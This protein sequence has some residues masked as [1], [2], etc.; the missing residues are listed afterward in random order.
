MRCRFASREVVQKKWQLVTLDCS[1]RILVPKYQQSATLQKTVRMGSSQGMVGLLGPKCN[2]NELSPSLAR[3]I[4]LGRC[5]NQVPGCPAG[6]HIRRSRRTAEATEGLQ[7]FGDLF[8]N[9]ANDE[10]GSKRAADPWRITAAGILMLVVVAQP[11][12]GM[13]FA[14]PWVQRALLQPRHQ[15]TEVAVPPPPC[16]SA[17]WWT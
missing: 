5:V 16:A 10:P 13:P 9:Q 14:A 17:M 7:P 2:R 8:A 4:A 15:L 1:H 6:G 11:L 12:E 3:P